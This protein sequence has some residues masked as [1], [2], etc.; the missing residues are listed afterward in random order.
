MNIIKLIILKFLN[1]QNPSCGAKN[2]LVKQLTTMATIA[3]T[4][5]S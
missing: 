3:P 5:S 4:I 1:N 2:E